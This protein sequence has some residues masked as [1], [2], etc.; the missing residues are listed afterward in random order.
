VPGASVLLHGDRIIARFDLAVERKAGV[1][2][3]IGERW[4]P[5]WEGGRRPVRETQ[6]ALSELASFLGVRVRWMSRTAPRLR[7]RGESAHR[8]AR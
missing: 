7:P 2:N 6:Q 3:V 1:L 8:G 4:E 5:G